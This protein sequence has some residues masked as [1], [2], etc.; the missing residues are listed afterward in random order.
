M[1][2]AGK[3]HISNLAH[4]EHPRLLET[5]TFN[6]FAD[7]RIILLTFAN[8]LKE[9]VKTLILSRPGLTS[10]EILIFLVTLFSVIYF[11]IRCEI[12]IIFSQ[13]TLLCLLLYHVFLILSLLVGGVDLRLEII[14]SLIEL[15]NLIE[16]AL[17]HFPDRCFILAECPLSL[18]LQFINCHALLQLVQVEHQGLDAGLD[19]KLESWHY[20]RHIIE[21]LS[22]VLEILVL[23]GV[24]YVWFFKLL[25][26]LL[27][28]VP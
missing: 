18:L 23:K 7:P 19:I 6:I 13:K 3:D 2:K 8:F 15:F 4:S 5:F 9:V 27:H 21:L 10:N 22:R 20:R 28:A 17:L 26:Q 24:V 11:T 1:V 25:D 14:T 16:Q 12:K